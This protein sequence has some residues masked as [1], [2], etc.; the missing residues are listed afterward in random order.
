MVLDTAKH[1][2]ILIRILKDI[3]TDTNIGPLLG[4]K[5]GTAAYLFYKLSRVSL[6]L[7]FDLLD[8][9][10]EGYVFAKIE[11][12]LKDYGQIK[13]LRK[14]RFSLF[15]VLSYEDGAPNIKIEIN[16][17][18]FG[19]RYEVKSYLGISMK[20]MVPEDMFAHKLVAMYERMGKANRDIFDV[21]FFL[22]RDWP[23]NKE[24][25]EKRTAMPF[26]KFLQKGINVL[27]K[28]P[29]RGILAGMGELLDAKQKDWV[30]TKLRTETIFQL[31]LKLES[32]K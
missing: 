24:I 27:E 3:Y 31:K 9:K 17:R 6:D 4:F 8:N 22:Q 16:R 11:E 2:S 25:V 5:D 10:K 7:D 29:D 23:I 14:K 21:W 28:L 19:S 20:V 13:E 15:L 32:E 12:I 1:K 26:K 18:E 30:R